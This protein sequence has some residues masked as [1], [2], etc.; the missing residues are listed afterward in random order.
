[1][2]QSNQ[3]PCF[4]CKYCISQMQH[5]VLCALQ[6]RFQV[7]GSPNGL[8]SLWIIENSTGPE[9]QK[10]LWNSSSETKQDKGWQLV[11]FPLFGLVD[12]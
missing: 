9:S 2:K 5:C 11:T 10:S 6:V 3:M 12:S 8:L 1:M 7:C 4:K